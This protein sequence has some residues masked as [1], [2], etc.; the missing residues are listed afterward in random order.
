MSSTPF[1]YSSFFE[2][3]RFKGISISNI[4]NTKEGAG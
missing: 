1:N 3:S 4:L 2:E